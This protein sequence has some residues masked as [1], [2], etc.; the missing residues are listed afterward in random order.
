MED[1]KNGRFRQTAI[2]V[3]DGI[4]VAMEIYT[5]MEG[6]LQGPRPRWQGLHK[7]RQPRKETVYKVPS[8]FLEFKRMDVSGGVR[9]E[10]RASCAVFSRTAVQRE[11]SV[12]ELF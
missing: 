7:R 5:S 2:A 8:Q 1:V 12:M 4:R 3:K 11:L 6:D 10:D 9:E